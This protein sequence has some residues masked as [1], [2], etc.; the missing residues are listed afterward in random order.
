LICLCALKV[1]ALKAEL[2]KLSK[3]MNFKLNLPAN[4]PAVGA[5]AAGA[6]DAKA[7]ANAGGSAGAQANAQAQAKADAKAQ[8]ALAADPGFQALAKLS[9]AAQFKADMKAAAGINLNSP[10]AKCMMNGLTASL[11]AS[12][13]MKALA[14]AP[15]GALKKLTALA[16]LAAT[17]EMAKAALGVDLLK[18]GAGAALQKALNAQAAAQASANGAA[19]GSISPAMQ[20]QAN[21]QAKADAVA[22]AEAAVKQAFGIDLK[23]DVGLKS[24]AAAMGATGDNMAGMPSLADLLS[25]SMLSDMSKMLSALDKIESGLGVSMLADG[26]AAKLGGALGALNS[27]GVGS[28]GVGAGGSA[29]SSASAGGSAGAGASAGAGGSA[30]ASA[31]ASPSLAA[32]AA[33][34]SQVNAMM[35]AGLPDIAG[36]FPTV[37]PSAAMLLMLLKQIGSTMHLNMISFTPCG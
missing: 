8:A 18:P 25:M 3:N 24:T 19:G 36:K 32:G 11:K 35:A 22:K 30:G 2:D 21:A 15:L 10:S 28:V 5:A 33:A 37:P 31:G 14:A 7:K 1:A 16:D 9:A 6:L 12:D 4:L 27:N 26:A 29:G 17:N 34:Q 23:A 20:A 13:F